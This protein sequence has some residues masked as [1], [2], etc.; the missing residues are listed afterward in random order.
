MCFLARSKFHLARYGNPS[1]RD[2]KAQKTH[3]PVN[4]GQAGPTNHIIIMVVTHCNR[5]ILDSLRYLV[6]GKKTLSTP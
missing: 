4:S 3:H 2:S 6:G 1:P 5:S